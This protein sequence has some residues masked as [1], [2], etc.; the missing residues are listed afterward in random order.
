MLKFTFQYTSGTGI[1]GGT[2]MTGW[3]GKVLKQWTLSS[4]LSAGSGLPQTPIFLT[5]L[6]ETGFTGTIRPNRT[7][8][9][10]YAATN[11]YH[12]N[13]AAYATPAAG[14]FGN[15]G[16]YSIEGPNQVTLD[17]SLARVFKL[18]DPLSLD[19][20]ID[21]TNVLNHVAFSGWNTITNGSTFGLP[22]SQRGSMRSFE[23]SGRLRF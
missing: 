9:D 15:A 6:P 8:A 1:G 17:S 11:G 12:L 2:L 13:A 14:Q 19:V 21:S 7:A 4:A 10:L 3:R 5:T 20:R 22:A 23:L 16:R 18:R